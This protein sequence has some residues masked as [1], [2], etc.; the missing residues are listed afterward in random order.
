[1]QIGIKRTKNWQIRMCVAS[2]FMCFC[3]E[4]SADQL[5]P[6]LAT[7]NVTV[8]SLDEVVVTARRQEQSAFELSGNIDR[9][10]EADL[11]EIQHQHI[12]E[13]M[14]RVAGVWI[15]RG[16]GQE[17]LTAIRSPVLAGAGSCGGFLFLE[18]GIPTRPSGFCNVNQMLELDSEQADSIE[19]IRG[20]GNALYGSN[21]LHGVINVLMPMPRSSFAPYLSVE[22][23]ANHYL[24]AKL[25]MPPDIDSPWF[26]S[27][28][29]TRDGGFRDD[30]DYQQFKLHTKREGRLLGGDV[31]YSFTLTDLDQNTAGFI[32]GKDA[33]KDREL[34]KM[35]LNPDA[36]RIAASQR[37]Y[38]LWNRSHD[39][40]DLDLRPFIRHS[41]M[42]FLHH[43]S[44]GTPLEQNGHTSAGMI[45]TL[46]FSGKE[47]RTVVGLDFEL[48]DVFLEEYQ[49]DP[50]KGPPRVIETRPQ[51]Q[52]YDY[53]VKSWSLAPYLQTEFFL[54]D[55]WTLG[56]GLRLET[57]HYDYDNKMLSG[58]TR[59]DGSECGFGG[60]LQSRPADRSDT[61]NNF[62][63]KLSV[64]YRP[65]ASMSMFAALLRGFRAPQT[66]ELYRLQNGQ[67][68]S[69]LDSEVID[70]LEL[71]LRKQGGYWYADI[72]M[73]AMKKRDSVFRDTQ[74]F[75][76]SGART[77]H[78]G[79]ELSAQL[80]LNERWSVQ[81]DGT[82]ARHT[83][84]FNFT[85]ERG[86]QIVSGRDV[87]SAPRLMGS[88]RVRYL[89]P[90]G[91][92]SELQWVYMGEYFLDAENRFEYEGH[93]LLGFRLGKSLSE[94][95]DL[96]FR[97]NNLTDSAYADRADY[98]FGDYRYFPG[99]GRELF[100]EIRYSPR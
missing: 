90:G 33:Y 69:D 19:V 40:F 46:S 98:G 29:Y 38:A 86:E 57:M 4:A 85:P 6:E 70:S 74:G 1:M 80:Q 58:N 23:G 41:E 61:F 52:H 88:F 5:E 42:E 96:N 53:D 100:A 17:H 12:A 14:S 32:F 99:R 71:G 67:Q 81:L 91:F 76:V 22:Y 36:F 30:S 75:N 37:L 66:S 20:P 93:S 77:R 15:V 35:N 10:S 43:F 16:S 11:T 59:D 2:L 55:Q 95:I 50:A 89:M 84:D 54:T 21:A 9:L 64:N 31:V 3:L 87:D 24:R 92:R 97:L 63:P 47:H 13:L 56:A 26:V 78:V 60:C 45:S 94:E 82:W 49:S 28:A 51:G 18:D 68:I 62:A 65:H 73:F 79:M 39:R 25:A 83:Y 44:P 48:A 34:S 72:V 8:D 27:A 7:E